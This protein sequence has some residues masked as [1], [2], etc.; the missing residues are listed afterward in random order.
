VPTLERLLVRW[1]VPFEG[2]LLPRQSWAVALVLAC[3][4]LSRR[5]SDPA[6]SPP[7]TPWLDAVGLVLAVEHGD[8]RVASAGDDGTTT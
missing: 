3:L 1:A 8:V 2:S 5:C 7:A 4:Q 6:R